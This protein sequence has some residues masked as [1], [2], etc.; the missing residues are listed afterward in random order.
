MTAPTVLLPHTASRA[1][2][3]AARRRGITATKI[4]AVAGVHPWLSALE[5]Y[6]DMVGVTVDVEENTAMRAGTF[7]EPF[8]CRE[9]AA[10]TG[11]A[12]ARSGLLAHPDRAW[13][14]AT[15]DRL[16]LKPGRTSWFGKWVNVDSLL[17]AKTALGWGALAWSDE[18]PTHVQMQV[19]W[20]LAVTGLDR[21]W[22]VALAGPQIKPFAVER[23]DELIADLTDIGEAFLLDHVAR[24]V[25]PTPD[26]TE[27]TARYLAR[28][29]PAVAGASTV[30]DPEQ[31][32]DLTVRYW[33]AHRE[34]AEY[35][36]DKTA[37]GN[38]M[39]LLLGPAEEGYLPGETKP[40]VTFRES[41]PVRFDAKALAADQP[42]LYAQY[43]RPASEPQ[44]TLSPRKPPRTSSR[45]EQAA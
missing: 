8:I 15:P 25:P 14:M 4:A 12:I 13:Q 31:W 43:R 20:Q 28:R 18:V 21:A 38:A 3:L 34:A 10:D 2:W 24:K 30:L 6:D 33:D 1:D 32:A 40:V 9:W 11:R 45:K 36:K 7:L 27:R 5:V 29:T 37:A 22:V 39:R 41:Y 42:D 16:V 17:E 23:D 44:R 35:E 19:Q 26:G